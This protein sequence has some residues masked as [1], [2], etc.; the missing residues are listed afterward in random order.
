MDGEIKLAVP[1]SEV[2]GRGAAELRLSYIFMMGRTSIEPVWIHAKR[3]LI[4]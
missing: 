4:F 1:E 2:R 3:F